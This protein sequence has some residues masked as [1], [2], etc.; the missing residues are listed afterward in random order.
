MLKT[1]R[2][3]EVLELDTKMFG[4][5]STTTPAKEEQAGKN[6]LPFLQELPSLPSVQLPNF[7]ELTGGFPHAFSPPSP[8]Q[9]PGHKKQ[10]KLTLAWAI[11]E[12]VHL[13]LISDVVWVISLFLS[14]CAQA[15]TVV[16]PIVFF[17]AVVGMEELGRR[18]GASSRGQTSPES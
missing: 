2:K 18:D 3:R 10:D 14:P 16:D 7:K 4:S 5:S 15:V 1:R 13:T 8:H 6:K 9:D 17:C 11:A 12:Y